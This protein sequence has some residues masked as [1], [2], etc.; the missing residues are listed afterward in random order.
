MTNTQGYTHSG[1][2]VSNNK[3]KI[4]TDNATSMQMNTLGSPVPVEKS[5]GHK[6]QGIDTSV[7]RLRS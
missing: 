4:I 5:K 3:G 2:Q 1:I 7:Q 6:L